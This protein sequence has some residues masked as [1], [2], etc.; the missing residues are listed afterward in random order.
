MSSMEEIRKFAEKTLGEVPK[1]IDLLSR[2]EE[3]A[4]IEQF[5]ENINLYLGR[6]AL[7]KKISALIAMSVALANGP[8]ES[9]II[10]FKLSKRFGADNIEILDAIRATKMAVMS[11]LLDSLD[12]IINNQFLAKKI[13]GSTE[14]YELIDELQKN[15]GTVPDRVIRLAKVSTESAREH[16]R[17]RNEL[18]I[19]SLKLNKKYMFAIALAVS[20]S[21]RDKECV[22][23]YLDMFIKN[24]GNLDEILDILSITRFISGNRAFVNATDILNELT[25]KE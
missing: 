21:L 1:V 13:K 2:I 7:P 24:G 18:L 15:V 16:L 17:E 8:K 20:T 12:I 14:S 5:D 22:K 19:N 6:S 9:A 10:H 11:S 4:A 23:T 3:K 25:K